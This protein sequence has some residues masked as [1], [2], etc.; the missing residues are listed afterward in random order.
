KDG[1]GV[2]FNNAIL[3]TF[4]VMNTLIALN[5]VSYGGSGP[6]V[7][8]PFSSQGHNL[9]GD[10]TGN[11]NAWDASDLVGT[12]QNPLDPKLGPLANNGGPTKT[13]ALLRGSPAIDSGNNSGAPATDQRGVHR[14]RDGDANGSQI[15]DIGAFER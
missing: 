13:Y 8:G 3:G 7:S 6:D 4:T 10:G 1:G 12:P 15:V 9:I 5:L 14:P 2:A 11:T